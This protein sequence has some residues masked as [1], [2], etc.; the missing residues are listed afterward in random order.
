MNKECKIL[1][2]KI[3]SFT[4]KSV[5]PYLS[6]G[7]HFQPFLKENIQHFKVKR[8]YLVTFFSFCGPFLHSWIWAA[9]PM[10]IRIQPAR[11]NSVLWGSGS[12]TLIRLQTVS[13][14]DQGPRS[15]PA[16]LG[17]EICT[18]PV[19]FKAFSLLKIKRLNSSLIT[20][21]CLIR[22]KVL[23]PAVCY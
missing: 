11:I 17:L 14:V 18:V 9:F 4:R 2:E 3:L 15:Y 1:A 19:Q 21:I 12:A 23:S 6:L 16:L 7:L 10:L 5:I 22:S 20:D 8:W 13:V